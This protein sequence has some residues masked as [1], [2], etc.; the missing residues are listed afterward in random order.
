MM[1]PETI[2]P[3]GSTVWLEVG[4]YRPPPT[5]PFIAARLRML[6]DDM[7]YLAA[8][9]DYYGGFAEWSKHGREIAGAGAIARQ[10]A[11]EI[12]TSNAEI[13]RPREAD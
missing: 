3:V 8:C 10:W 2:D 4:G 13:S 11:D 6:A 12:E 1:K 7:E 9:M 5:K